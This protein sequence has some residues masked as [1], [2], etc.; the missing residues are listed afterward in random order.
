MEWRWGNIPRP[1]A[2]GKWEYHELKKALPDKVTWY[3]YNMAMRLKNGVNK[4]LGVNDKNQKDPKENAFCMAL[5]LTAYKNGE[6][7][8]NY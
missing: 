4:Y 1:N 3:D 6:Y 7:N 2:P 8:P 5:L